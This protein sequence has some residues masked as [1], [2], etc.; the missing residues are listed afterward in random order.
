MTTETVIEAFDTSFE[1]GSTRRMAVRVHS[2]TAT[3]T[4]DTS[5]RGGPIKTSELVDLATLLGV[6]LSAV[7]VW[8]AGPEICEIGVDL[9]ERTPIE[10]PIR[11]G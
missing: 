10:R 4:V 6:D 5:H 1:H 8:D 11:V 7:T 9:D 3:I 2:W